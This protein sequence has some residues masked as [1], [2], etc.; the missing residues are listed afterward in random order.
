MTTMPRIPST[1]NPSSRRKAPF[2]LLVFVLVLG[3]LIMSALVGLVYPRVAPIFAGWEW[4]ALAAAALAWPLLLLCVIKYDWMVFVAFTLFT[5]VRIEPAPSI[6][7]SCSCLA[8]ASCSASSSSIR[9]A[10]LH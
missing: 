7:C 9:C 10:G 1:L 4:L 8:W 3:G 2:R 6:C 5:V